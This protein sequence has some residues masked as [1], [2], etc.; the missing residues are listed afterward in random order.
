MLQDCYSRVFK[1]LRLSL[2]DRCNFKCTYCLPEGFNPI[3]DERHLELPEIRNLVS[4]F[5]EL[6]IQKIRLTGGEPTLRSDILEIIRLIKSEL[7][8]EEVG[9]TTNGF[10]LKN[11]GKQ[12]KQVGL[13]SVNISLDSLEPDQFKNICGIDRGGSVLEAIDQCIDLGFKSVKVNCVLLKGINHHEFWNFVKYVKHRPITVRF[14]E[15]METIDN[16]EFFER[17]RLSSHHLMGDLASLGWSLLSAK[18]TGG[19]A[20]EFWSPNS[21][22]KIGFISP[23][24]KNFCST[25]N[26]LRVS[27]KGGLRLCLFGQ[28][29]VSLRDLLQ[30]ESDKSQ[31][32]ERIKRSLMVKPLGHQLHQKVL[33]NMQ[34]LSAIGG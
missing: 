19:P 31:L 26:R 28:G 1:Y 16:K 4:A 21:A 6:G 7:G 34:S 23:Y 24:S 11:I 9:L 22:G 12:L 2:T 14:I 15:L 30:S 20:K 3:D 25:C 33:G 10:R 18:S 13:D 17:H 5:R 29:D 32:L 8:I 27:A